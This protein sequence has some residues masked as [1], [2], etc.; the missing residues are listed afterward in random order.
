MKG[1][2]KKKGGNMK[3][4]FNSPIPKQKLLKKLVLCFGFLLFAFFPTMLIQ[5]G[6]AEAAA[7]I[8]GTL[9]LPADANGKE[10]V[11]LVDNDFDGGNGF[12]TATVGTCGS[13][14]T[15]SYSI[16]DVPQGTYF[17]Y[18]LV[19]IISEPDSSPCSGDYM[20]YYDTGSVPPALA[21]AVVPSTGTVTF[22]IN[23]YEWDGDDDCNGGGG[24]DGGG[25][26]IIN[27]IR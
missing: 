4:K 23:V 20:G 1:T 8:D 27:A 14:T 26:F 16:A 24:G 25:C 21:N 22:D 5:E 9:Y 18:A 17:V 13:G 2:F 10:Y 15:V 7:T 11:V 6:L 12:I 3:I 19:R